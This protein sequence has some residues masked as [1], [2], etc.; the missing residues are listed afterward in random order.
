MTSTETTLLPIETFLGPIAERLKDGNVI[1]SAAPGAGK[2]TRL[3]LHL[4]RCSESWSGKIIVLQPRRVVVRALAHYLAAQLGEVVGQ[5]V[6][7][8]IRGERKVSS[9]TRLEIITE[10]VLTRQFQADP[11]LSSVGLLV[12]DEF[13]ERNVHA[14][15]GLA[16]A[17]ESQQALR[18]D[19]RLLIMSATLD[20]PGLAHTLPEAAIVDVPGRQFP[21]HYHYHPLSTQQARTS[22]QSV[23]LS[24]QLTAHAVSLLPDVLAAHT[25]DV[26]VFLPGAAEI[27][28]AMTAAC[29][30]PDTVLVPLYGGLTKQEQDRA[31]QPDRQTRRK[32]VLATNIA[33]TSL[34]IEGIR[35]VIDTGL[36]R[37]VK[38]D[39]R[40]DIEQLVTLR[41]SQASAHQRAGRAGRMAEGHCY[42]LWSPAQQERLAAQAPVPMLECDVTDMVLHAKVWG[43]ELDQLPLISQPSRAQLDSA[44]TQLQ[45]LRAISDDERVTEHGRALLRV[46][47]IPRL[48][49]MLLSIQDTQGK[50]SVWLHAAAFVAMMDEFGATFD[51]AQVN[52]RL[53]AYKHSRNTASAMRHNDMQRIEQRMI[54]LLALFDI[55]FDFIALKSV[56]HEQ[57]AVCSATAWPDRIAFATDTGRLK[58]SGGKQASLQRDTFVT[59]GN[60]LSVVDIRINPSGE[61]IVYAYEP[62]SLQLLE[63][64]LPSD[65]TQSD[66]VLWDD[67]TQRWQRRQTRSF[68]AIEFAHQALEFNYSLSQQAESTLQT[69]WLDLLHNK[70]VQWLPLSA[71]AQSLLHRCRIAQQCTLS[72]ALSPWPDFSDEALIATATD[73]L[74]PFLG[75][76]RSYKQLSTLAWPELIRNRLDWTQQQWLDQQL[77]KRLS[78][79]TGDNVSIDYSCVDLQT[80]LSQQGAKI[81]VRMQYVFGLAVSPCL[82][83]GELGLSFELL[84]PAHRPLQT[85]RDLGQFWQSDSYTAIKKEM[86][87]RYPK[88]LWPNDPANTQPTKVTKAKMQRG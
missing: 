55:R 24:K 56:S 81:S 64:A 21:I 80:D 34:T 53:R 35:I 72:E 57:L 87:G 49:H 47:L 62:I 6:G 22:G 17:I 36:E 30:P 31:I 4:L 85:T 43:T 33:E 61:P 12:F 1:L 16:L 83:N 7:Y 11:E 26:L 79:P 84:S 38:L 23:S 82:A 78:L 48:A 29:V 15:F 77:P 76:C 42:R 28:L 69:L 66:M 60:W 73:W 18:P 52:E 71:E 70:G 68:G 63:E 25:G 54:A 8:R 19:L 58:L 50:D 5:Q 86:K 37:R 39:L 10:G 44:R 45:W 20:V 32:V 88:H 27:K 65:F 41:V 9:S 74:M 13:H 2:S 46:P 75:N 59:P 51:H 40:S 3:L 67:N 14:D